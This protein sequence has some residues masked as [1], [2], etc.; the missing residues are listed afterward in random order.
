M[1][2]DTLVKGRQTTREVNVSG[3]LLFPFPRKKRKRLKLSHRSPIEG[4][5]KTLAPVHTVDSKN[6]AFFHIRGELKVI[7]L[8]KTIVSCNHRMI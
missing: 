6:S 8:I 3:V 4:A 2:T 5:L 1:L 7:F